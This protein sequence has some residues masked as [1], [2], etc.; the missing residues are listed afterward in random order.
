MTPVPVYET[1]NMY[2]IDQHVVNDI[3]PKLIRK[4][5]KKLK[6]DDNHI[7]DTFDALGGKGLTKNLLFCNSQSCDPIHPND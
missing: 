3:F 1:K 2:K 6:L 7:I 4:I 5:A